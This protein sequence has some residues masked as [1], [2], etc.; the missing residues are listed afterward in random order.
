M[1]DTI[2][3]TYKFFNNSPKRQRFFERVLDVHGST[4]NKTKLAG[5]CK[6]RWTERHTCYETFLELYK[7]IHICMDAI[8]H[9]NQHD[10]LYVGDGN[11]AWDPE[12]KIK[13]QGVYTSIESSE[14]I[15]TKNGLTP[16]K[17]LASKLQKRDLDVYEAHKMVDTC[18]CISALSTMRTNIDDVFRDWFADMTDL[19]NSI[20][21]VIQTRR[22][23]NKQIN[24]QNTPS[25]NPN[26][27]FRRNVAVPFIDYLIQEMT[28]R[29]D[30]ENRN[31]VSMFAL[32]PSAIVDSQTFDELIMKLR[33]WE[34]DLPTHS[35]LKYELQ[36]WKKY[37]QSYE[38]IKPTNLVECYVKADCDVFPNIN[39]LLRIGCALPVGSAEAERSFS[40][41]RR[42]RTHLRTTMSEERLAGLTLL[43]IHKSLAIDIDKLIRIFAT[44]NKRK[45]FGN[46]FQE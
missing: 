33:F 14:F 12:T 43:S 38:G 13:A 24:R 9:P 18:S 2:N 4:S 5:L 21:T 26:D 19:A 29:F 34:G 39:M 46:L 20:N 16:I 6:T 8:L 15:V 25:D 44:R 31:G 36:Q 27:H 45:M 40:A 17:P 10:E 11:W 37:W 23:T 28:A 41:L 1:I 32:L 42:V 35:S 22:I 7:Y 3:V 30:L